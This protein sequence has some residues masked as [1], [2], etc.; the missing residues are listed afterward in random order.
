MFFGTVV[1][2]CNRGEE[3]EGS[4]GYVPCDKWLDELNEGDCS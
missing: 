3:T 2:Y 1:R 4:R